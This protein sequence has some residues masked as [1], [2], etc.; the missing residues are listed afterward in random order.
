MIEAAHRLYV[1]IVTRGVLDRKIRELC[2][3]AMALQEGKAE[4]AVEHC[5]K[6]RVAGSTEDE[7]MEVA[8]IVC[9]GA[10]K[11]SAARSSIMMTEAFKKL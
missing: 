7:I 2:F 9:C 4:S 8:A 5:Q 6:A 3:L 11:R 10:G 1:D